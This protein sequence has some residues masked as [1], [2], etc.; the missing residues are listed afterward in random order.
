MKNQNS[1]LKLMPFIIIAIVIVGA[2]YL[3]NQGTNNFPKNT[4][5][6]Y[7]LND[8]VSEIKTTQDLN[9]QLENLDKIDV[10]QINSAITNNETD[11]N[12]F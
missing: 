3:I 5:E 11:T 12:N 6:T 9:T 1:F 7:Q 10:D 4:T 8:Q 2:L